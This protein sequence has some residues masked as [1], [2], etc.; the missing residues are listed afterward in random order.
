[1]SLATDACYLDNAAAPPFPQSLLKAYT[2]KLSSPTS[3]YGNPHSHSPS[4]ISTATA[5][6]DTRAHVLKRLFHV[7]TPGEEGAWTVVFTSGATASL[8]LVAECFDW[9]RGGAGGAGEFRYADEAHTSLVGLRDIVASRGAVARSFSMQDLEDGRLGAPTTSSRLIGMPLQCNATGRKFDMETIC[10]TKSTSHATRT[11]LLLDAAA[12][13]S[14]HQTLDLSQIPYETAPDYIAFSFYKIFGFPTGLGGL[15]VKRSAIEALSQ[16]TYFGGGTVDAITPRASWRVPRKDFAARMEDGTVNFHGILAVSC[17]IEVFDDMFGRE[18]ERKRHVVGLTKRLVDGCVRLRHGNGQPVCRIYSTSKDV[19]SWSANLGSNP[20]NEIGDQGSTIAFNLLTS[21]GTVVPPT[22]V[23]RLACIQNIHLRAGRHCNAGVVTSQV[24]P[25]EADLIEQYRSGMGCDES[26]NGAIVSA[27]VRVSLNVA[28]TRRDVDRFVGFI[29][30]FF[31]QKEMVARS[32]GAADTRAEASAYHLKE[33]LVYPIK[34]CAAQRIERGQRW[35]LTP[36]GL[37]HDREWVLVDTKTGQALSQKRHYRMALIRSRIDLEAQ[38]MR[39]AFGG[40]EFSVSIAPPRQQQDQAEFTI[41]GDSAAPII[42][43]DPLLNQ[44]LSEFLGLSCA[45]A[46]QPT[47]TRHSKLATSGQQASERIPLLLSN[48]SPFLLINGESVNTVSTW[49]HTSPKGQPARQAKTTSF[50]GNFT[51]DSTL[52][53][54]PRP[55]AEDA[56][57]Q[58]IIGPHVFSALGPCRRCQMVAIDQET[59]ERAPETFLALARH[60]RNERGRIVFGMHLTWRR[61][62]Q[63]G[64]PGDEGFVEVGMPVRLYG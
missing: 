12:Y 10:K 20:M 8:K 60:R 11:Y 57:E 35:P 64:E 47:S 54:T 49:M 40:T 19:K 63:G 33:L 59:G 30:R 9:H 38:M 55:F 29:R 46:R 41:C 24:G 37:C 36:E 26:A 50:R 58:V 62:L 28:N 61:D 21:N 4:S 51:I 31:V 53:G 22:E 7:E 6:A 5:I 32:I 13:L 56:V 25:T 45:L 2:H 16:K 34:S 44:T 27:S 1:M 18:D 14:A 52:P 3:L 39:I 43:Q 42:H 15:V 17:G 48:E 23:D